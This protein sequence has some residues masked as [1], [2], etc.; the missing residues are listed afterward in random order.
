MK[1]DILKAMVEF[2]DD[3]FHE[4]AGPETTMR[5]IGFDSLD[6][7]EMLIAIEATLNISIEDAMI[8][9]DSED[10]TFDRLAGHVATLLKHER[11]L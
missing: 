8:P 1:E 6:C 2:V 11:T 4:K 9:D 10:W 3:M 5:G 7:V